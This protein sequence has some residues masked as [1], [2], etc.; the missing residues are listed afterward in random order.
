MTLTN[1]QKARY[2][3]INEYAA[4]P[5]LLRDLLWDVFSV[6]D[7]D[8]LSIRND[9]ITK[10]NKLV[11]KG[12]TPFLDK[13]GEAMVFIAKNEMMKESNGKERTNQS[14]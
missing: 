9:A 5:Q 4:S 2:D 7:P 11:N 10:V 12:R 1:E 13:V 6:C 8:Q 3:R 14:L